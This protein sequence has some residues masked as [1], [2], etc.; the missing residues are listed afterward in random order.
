MANPPARLKGT[1][2]E[3]K[4][5]WKSYF[6][7]LLGQPPKVP[8]DNFVVSQV[9]DHILPI[10]EGP[11]TPEELR[12][13]IRH[14]KR[15]GAVGIDCIPLEIWEDPYFSNY[16][17]ELCNLGLN[18]H[19]KPKQWSQSAIKPIPKKTNASLKQH[20]GISLNSIAAKLYN[21]M[22][23]NRIQPYDDPILS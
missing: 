15:G 3:K 22:L 13:A 18:Q 17:L 23:L 14:T 1:P 6:S 12:K 20:R 5:Q 8:D 10:E 16:L 9:S 2:E 21:K 7:S 11:F 19:L 4:E